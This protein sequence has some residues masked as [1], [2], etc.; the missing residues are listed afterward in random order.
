[1]EDGRRLLAGD[2]EHVRDHEEKSLRGGE[3]ACERASLKGTV[4]RADRAGLAL[5]FHDL[6]DRAEKVF[7]TL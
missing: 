7:L 1:M 2:L 5:H 6:R 4:N 3:G